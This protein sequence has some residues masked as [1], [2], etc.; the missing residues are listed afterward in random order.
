MHH[1]MCA[2]LFPHAHNVSS[3]QSL[4]AAGQ[5]KAGQFLPAMMAAVTAN[6]GFW[7]TLALNIPDFSRFAKSQREQVIGQAV[8][9]PLFM[10]AFSFVGVAVTSATV[11]MYGNP[12]STCCCPLPCAHPSVAPLQF[13]CWSKF[14]ALK[15]L[16][17]ALHN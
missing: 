1:T 11:A 9:L 7:A 15:L 10:A 13:L 4:F 16:L 6:V 17:C 5:A 14:L 12:I 8:G 3:S 2:L